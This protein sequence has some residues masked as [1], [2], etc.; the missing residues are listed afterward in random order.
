MSYEIK[1]LI[2]EQNEQISKTQ[3]KKQIKIMKIKLEREF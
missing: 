2:K 1:E 3:K